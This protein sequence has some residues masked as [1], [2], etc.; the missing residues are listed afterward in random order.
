MPRGLQDRR[1]RDP[2]NFSREEWQQAKRSGIDPREI[3]SALHQCWNTSDNRSSFEAPLKE[4]GFWLAKG[5][6][7]GFV[8]LD[9]RGEVYSLS[10][11]SGVNTKGLVL[12]E[13]GVAD[14]QIRKKNC[15]PQRAG[16]RSRARDGSRMAETT[17][18]VYDSLDTKWCAIK[19]VSDPWS[20]FWLQWNR[21]WVNL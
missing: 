18:S 3:K 6:R 10:R 16:I 7:R 20:S 4:R 5:D 14:P 19:C 8:A 9:Y 12:T 2:L 21:Y 1:L 17:G 11:Y 13:D 15:Q